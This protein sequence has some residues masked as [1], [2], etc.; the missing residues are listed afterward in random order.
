MKEKIKV[1]SQSRNIIST[2]IVV[3]IENLHS[4]RLLNTNINIDCSSLV[5]GKL[6]IRVGDQNRIL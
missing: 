1:F 5:K 2:L 3:Y 4:D 6:G